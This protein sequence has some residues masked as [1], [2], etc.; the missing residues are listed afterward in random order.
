MCL[1][2]TDE[3]MLSCCNMKYVKTHTDKGSFLLDSCP[4]A[5]HSYKLKMQN[6]RIQLSMV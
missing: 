2:L 6:P 3:A 5:T 4:K 1:H